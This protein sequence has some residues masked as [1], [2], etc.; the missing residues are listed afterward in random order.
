VDALRCLRGL[1]TG[2]GEAARR[3]RAGIA[4]TRAG[5]PRAGLPVT[6]VHGV[7]DGLVPVAFSSAPYVAMAH[8]AGRDVGFWRVANAQHFDA[9]LQLPP[10]GARYVPLLP[11]VYAALDR[12]WAH[13]YN[14]APLPGDADIATVPRG[15]EPALT[16]KNLP[17]PT[18]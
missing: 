18:R 14:G 9:F 10:M 6:I 3:V 13:L 16:S 8:A 7:N 2:D 17:M 4:E 1:W 11:Y 15:A 5:P 12:T